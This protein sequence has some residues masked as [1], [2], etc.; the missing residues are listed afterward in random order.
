[1]SVPC[2]ARL[3]LTAAHRSFVLILALAQPSHSYPSLKLGCLAG[4]VDARSLDALVDIIEAAVPSFNA[5][6][7]STGQLRPH[8]DKRGLP[9][10]LPGVRPELYG[11]FLSPMRPAQNMCRERL[12]NALSHVMKASA[13]RHYQGTNTW[14]ACMSLP[15]VPVLPA[16]Q[17]SIAWPRRG[18]STRPFTPPCSN[19]WTL[20]S[21]C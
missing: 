2:P 6:N 9:W 16:L 14:Q 19:E 12:H 17:L 4:L 15:D 20:C 3:S 21:T 1:M 7:A 13:P 8:N 5:V 18:Q 11:S 10:P